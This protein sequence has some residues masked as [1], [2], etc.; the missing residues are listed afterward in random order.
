MD[1]QTSQTSAKKI[2]I[3]EDES[4]L[5]EALSDKFTQEK[6]TVFKA[7][8]GDEGLTVALKEHPDLILLDIIMPQMD[9]ITML[10][11]IRKDQ[12]GATVPVFMLTNVNDSK[13]ISEA[14]KYKVH[15]FFVKADMDL[16]EI[17]NEANR[18]I[19]K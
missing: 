2:L 15:H 12:W 9:G 16:A 13:S 6:F 7:T 3:V 4:M 5:L 8:N 17:V 1:E 18:T 19:G 10:D 14:M 11:H